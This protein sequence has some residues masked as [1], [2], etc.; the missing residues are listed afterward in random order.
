M[1]SIHNADWG[2][3]GKNIMQKGGARQKHN[4]E[5]GRKAK[6]V[7]NHCSNASLVVIHASARFYIFNEY[8]KKLF[9]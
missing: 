7:K 8:L 9:F 2:A 3:Q 6:K 1:G 4:A 5:G